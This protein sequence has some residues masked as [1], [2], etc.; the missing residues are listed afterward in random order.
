LNQDVCGS[1]FDLVFGQSTWIKQGK[2]RK[3]FGWKP[4]AHLST[5]ANQFRDVMQDFAIVSCSGDAVRCVSHVGNAN[6]PQLHRPTRPRNLRPP[7]K[8]ELRVCRQRVSLALE[9]QNHKVTQIG[10]WNPKLLIEVFHRKVQF[11]PHE[12]AKEWN[13]TMNHSSGLSHPSLWLTASV[14]HEPIG[15][16]SI[17]RIARRLWEF[18]KLSW[19]PRQSRSSVIQNIHCLCPRTKS[20]RWRLSGGSV[21]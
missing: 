4:G 10:R 5:R 13:R 15:M 7:L 12:I 16:D 9:G 18:V 19:K 2:D 6:N 8:I 21:C 1:S 20:S 3:W 14:S 17:A 11:I